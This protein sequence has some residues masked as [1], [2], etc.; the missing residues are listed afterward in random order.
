MELDSSY[1]VIEEEKDG[2]DLKGAKANENEQENGEEKSTRASS[3]NL[4]KDEYSF[5]GE[6][7]SAQSEK[8]R[9]HSPFKDLKSWRVMQLI[10]KSGAD[11]KE[12]QFALQLISQFDQIWKAAKIKLML[13]PY[14]IV[15]LGKCS[16]LIFCN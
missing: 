16:R 3:T 13:T 4:L 14:E 1:T 15:S 11:L 7:S 2:S 9:K 12:E 5:F 6:D 10:I 8:I